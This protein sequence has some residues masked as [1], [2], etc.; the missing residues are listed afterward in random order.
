MDKYA[1]GKDIQRILQL[2][3]EKK[4]GCAGSHGKEK[5][6]I[7][8]ASLEV[9]LAQ[10]SDLAGIANLIDQPPSDGTLVAQKV[11]EFKDRWGVS[12][13]GKSNFCCTVYDIDGN[14]DK[15]NVQEYTRAQ[16]DVY[17]AKK[18]GNNAFAIDNGKC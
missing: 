10:F 4:C 7:P 15:Y 17:C 8:A 2:L 13:I 16:A 9:L 1:L 6:A 18:A 11:Q 14:I 12:E 3:E 5:V